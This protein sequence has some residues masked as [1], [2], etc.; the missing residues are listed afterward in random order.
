[1]RKQIFYPLRYRPDGSLHFHKDQ[2]RWSAVGEFA[3]ILLLTLFV[4]L[5]LSVAVLEPFGVARAQERSQALVAVPG[6]SARK[7]PI[8]NGLDKWW[9]NQGSH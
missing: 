5:L 9:D 7:T 3:A 4:L 2:S 8:V 1:V 6:I